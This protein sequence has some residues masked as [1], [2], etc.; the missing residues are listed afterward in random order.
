MNTS[1]SEPVFWPKL[2]EFSAN[3]LAAVVLLTERMLTLAKSGDW[4]QVSDS[5][6]CRHG[7]AQRLL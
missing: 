7:V 2:S 4:D 5:E 6:R 1:A 3:A